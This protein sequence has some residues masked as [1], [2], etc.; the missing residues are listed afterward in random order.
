MILEGTFYFVKSSKKR[1]ISVTHCH[2]TLKSWGF[3][4]FFFEDGTKL[5]SASFAQVSANYLV[6]IQLG[7]SFSEIVGIWK[8]KDQQF[9]DIFSTKLI[10]SRS[11]TCT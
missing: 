9:D 1:K 6:I 3:A 7:Q 10:K 5:K 11:C 8:S 2:F 4:T